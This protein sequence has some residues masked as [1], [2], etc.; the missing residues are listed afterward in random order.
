MKAGRGL[1][2]TVGIALVIVAIALIFNSE[3]KE[4]EVLVQ[5]VSIEDIHKY[6]VGENYSNVINTIEK[7]E[8]KI[9][10]GYE[11]KY[12]VIVSDKSHNKIDTQYVIDEKSV[13][14]QPK[15]VETED[16]G[17]FIK[18]SKILM[19]KN[20]DSIEIKDIV[21]NDFSE[22]AVYEVIMI[23]DS[24]TNGYIAYSDKYGTID[25]EIM[26]YHSEG[27]YRVVLQNN[28][29]GGLD[30]HKSEKLNGIEITCKIKEYNVEGRNATIELGG[31]TLNVEVPTN[32]LIEGEK[33][34]VWISYDYTNSKFSIT[35]EE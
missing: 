28:D 18:R 19:I 15:F 25:K 16:S 3:E 26:G 24:N 1:L 12:A 7:G 35:L 5:E 29:K 9:I 22:K 27:V 6:D 21:A 14:I 8:S 23:K 20:A 17:L 32:S 4:L 31:N 11:C 2:V 33:Y 13:T 34:K 30:I 10:D